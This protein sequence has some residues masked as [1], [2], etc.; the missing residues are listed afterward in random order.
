MAEMGQMSPQ[1]TCLA[2]SQDVIG[3]KN[4]M[5]GRISRQFYDIQSKYL[6]LGNHRMDAGQ[7]TRQLISKFLHITHSKWIFRNFTLHDKQKGWLR[8]KKLHEVMEKI[9]QLGHTN[10]DKIP[11]GSRFLL[12]MD[13]DNL[14]K[15][16][17]HNKTYWVAAMEA[18]TKAGQRTTNRG[19]RS[20]TQLKRRQKRSTRERLRVID[21]EEEIKSDRRACKVIRGGGVEGS[22]HNNAVIPTP[23]KRKS[24]CSTSGVTTRTNKRHKPGD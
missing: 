12:E 22:S 18:A 3:W 24:L 13:Y 21:V 23:S 10:V 19:V 1:M 4:F 9:D 2:K 7:W 8:R 15:S 17:I 16:N 14:M 11:E 6:T 20:R 5:E